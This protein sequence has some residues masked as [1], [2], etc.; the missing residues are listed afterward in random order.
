VLDLSSTGERSHQ[1]FCEARF[2]DAKPLR[3]ILDLAFVLGFRADISDQQATT[4]SDLGHG[5]VE[6]T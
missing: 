2:D 6:K 4:S 5:G 3:P 1:S